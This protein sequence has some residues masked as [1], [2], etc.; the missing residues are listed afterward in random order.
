[1]ADL[2]EIEGVEEVAQMLQTL[3]KH[4]VASGFLKAGQAA[5]KVIKDAVAARTPEKTGDMKAALMMEVELDS[6]FRGVNVEIG[7]GKQGYKANF[8][9]YGHR[10]VGHQPEQKDLGTVEPHPF[11]RPAAEVSAEG[12]IDMFSET[13]MEELTSIPGWARGFGGL[14]SE[15]EAFSQEI[16]QNVA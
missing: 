2:I 15:E 9:E 5:G 8:V 11:M 12:A 10:M 6:D 4:V 7:F 16:I 14:S 3:P 1:M 13:L